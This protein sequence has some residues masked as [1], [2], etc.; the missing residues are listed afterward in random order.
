MNQLFSENGKRLSGKAVVITGATG[1]IGEARRRSS[2]CAKGPR[3]ARRTFGRQT[4]RDPPP[5][6]R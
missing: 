4:P 2:F 5:S 6:R 1:G 3:H